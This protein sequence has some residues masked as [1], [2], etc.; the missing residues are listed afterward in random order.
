[1]YQ[2]LIQFGLFLLLR[3]FL[4][5]GLW[6]FEDVIDSRVVKDNREFSARVMKWLGN[7]GRASPHAQS[8]SCSSSVVFTRVFVNQWNPEPLPECCI[9]VLGLEDREFIHF[10]GR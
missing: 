9:F 3:C 1:M 10:S 7:K 2:R 4:V 5:L 6:L 8:R